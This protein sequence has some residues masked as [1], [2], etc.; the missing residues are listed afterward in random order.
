MFAKFVM[1]REWAK[2]KK[3]CVSMQIDTEMI[4][5]ARRQCQYDDEIVVEINYSCNHF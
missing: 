1:I 5:C 4:T 3:G 2:E